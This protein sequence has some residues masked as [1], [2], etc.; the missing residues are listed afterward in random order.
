MDIIDVC[1]PLAPE[2]LSRAASWD[3]TDLI[4][5]D[6]VVYVTSYTG[7]LTVIDIADPKAPVSMGRVPVV[8]EDAYGVAIKDGYAYVGSYEFGLSILDIE[9]LSITKSIGEGKE[10]GDGY[11]VATNG[12]YAYVGVWW[13][14]HDKLTPRAGLAV[15][16]LADP[17]YPT[18]LSRL[19]TPGTHVRDI[20]SHRDWIYMAA[21][22]RGLQIVNVAAPDDPRFLATLYVDGEANGLAL[23]GDLGYLSCGNGELLVVDLTN[24]GLPEV[25]SRLETGTYTTGLAVADGRLYV[26]TGEDGARA[27]SLA[28]PLRPELLWIHDT[29]GQVYNITPD[30]RMLYVADGSAGITVIEVGKGIFGR[31]RFVDRLHTPGRAISP[32]V[33]D[34]ILYVADM[35]GGVQVFDVGEPE[36]YRHLGHVTEDICDIAIGEDVLV[37]ADSWARTIQTAPLHCPAFSPT[38]VHQQVMRTPRVTAG[39][40]IPNPFNPRTTISFAVQSAQRLTVGVYDASGRRVRGLAARHFPAG[41]HLLTWDG[42]DDRGQ[43]AAAGIY[44]VRLQAELETVTRKIALIR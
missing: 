36:S 30:G 35:S 18:Q 29:A 32:I 25:L 40:A 4:V 11:V 27:Y 16:D 12:H 33:V 20:V 28:S 26:G 1:N 31:P 39:P 8:E 6:G 24:P 37:L 13:L 15:Y 44:F 7:K 19:A 14:E 41:E 43:A 42:R 23:D 3:A 34:G 5:D 17:A 9:P 22:E 10:I 21:A 2:F 38:P